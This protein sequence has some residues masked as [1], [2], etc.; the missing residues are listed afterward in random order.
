MLIKSQRLT[1]FSPLF[2]KPRP[3]PVNSHQTL[4][5]ESVLTRRKLGA[6]DE[7]EERGSGETE[8]MGTDER[9]SEVHRSGD[10]DVDL[11]TVDESHRH[12]RHR[13]RKLHRTRCSWYAFQSYLY[14]RFSR[15][16]TGPQ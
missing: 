14:F 5:T 16:G 10:G 11:W 3:F 6:I 12:G 15:T 13:P 4:V 2:P 1:L 7:K 9:D 8:H